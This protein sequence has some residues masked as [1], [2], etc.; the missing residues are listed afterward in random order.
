MLDDIEVILHRHDDMHLVLMTPEL[1]PQRVSDYAWVLSVMV[2]IF[3]SDRHDVTIDVL[4]VV[5]P[6]IRCGISSCSPVPA[7]GSDCRAWC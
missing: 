7:S 6:R 5:D 3:S 1:Q 4:T 2:D